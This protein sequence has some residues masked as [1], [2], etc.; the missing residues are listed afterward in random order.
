MGV[1][2]AGF[3]KF[4][5]SLRPEA[6][7]DIFF[8]V[9]L[10]FVAFGVFRLIVS[11][12]TSDKDY[13]RRKEPQQQPTGIK[14]RMQGKAAG[15]LNHDLKKINVDQEVLRQKQEIQQRIRNEQLQRQRQGQQAQQPRPQAIFC[16]NCGTQNSPQANF[17]INCGMRLR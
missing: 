1:V 14:E 13:K 7:M 2:V 10:T 8:Y 16:P 11:Y 12:I 6:K 5:Q 3:S 4:I 15:M 9:G 17:C